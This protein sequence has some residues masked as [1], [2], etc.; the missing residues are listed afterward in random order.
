MTDER[1]LSCPID[2]YNAIID[3]F[4][5]ETITSKSGCSQRNATVS[6]KSGSGRAST[7]FI[8]WHTKAGEKWRGKV[9]KTSVALRDS[10]SA[11]IAIAAVDPRQ[12]RL[13]MLTLPFRFVQLENHFKRL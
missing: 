11:K 4:V 6:S 10:V 5:V 2:T 12:P 1:E 8:G 3:Q 7:I 9:E 13:A